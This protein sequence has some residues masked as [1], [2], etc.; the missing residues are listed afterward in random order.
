MNDAVTLLGFL[1]CHVFVHKV[2]YY[3][4]WTEGPILQQKRSRTESGRMDVDS[5]EASMKRRG[6]YSLVSLLLSSLLCY[7]RNTK[8]FMAHSHSKMKNEPQTRTTTQSKRVYVTFRT[9]EESWLSISMKRLQEL[10]SLFSCIL[11]SFCS[12][13]ILLSRKMYDSMLVGGGTVCVSDVC[14]AS[15]C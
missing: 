1:F 5:R 15:V 3:T 14:H 11:P 4:P 12:K 13:K 7:S 10:H 2:I 9:R 6:D 8:R